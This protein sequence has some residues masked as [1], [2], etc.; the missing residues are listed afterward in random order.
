MFRVEALVRRWQGCNFGVPWLSGGVV[1]L[2][3]LLVSFNI[4]MIIIVFF[5][6][7]GRRLGCLGLGVVHL[8]FRGLGASCGSRFGQA[9][10]L[11]A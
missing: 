11:R 4:R 7:G 8:E 1:F 10:G 2:L 6:G 5:L 9:L 3:L